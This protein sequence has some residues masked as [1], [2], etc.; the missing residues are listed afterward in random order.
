MFKI[1]S[2][3]FDG[4][5]VTVEEYYKDEKIKE[6]K[7]MIILLNSEYPNIKMD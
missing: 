2:Y 1:H 4:D 3:N 7:D 5:D 6:F